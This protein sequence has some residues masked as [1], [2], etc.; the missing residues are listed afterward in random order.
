MK[1]ELIILAADKNTQFALE[2]LLTR[3]QAFQMKEL[4]KED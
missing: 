2:G 1:K 3:H 4:T